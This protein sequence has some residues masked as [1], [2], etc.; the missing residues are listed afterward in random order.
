MTDFHHISVADTAAMLAQ[1][2]VVIA[3]IRDEQ[4]FA[5][6]HIAGAIHLSNGSLSQFIQQVEFEKPI[7]VVCYHGNSS[8]GAAQYLAQQGFAQVYSMDGGFSEWQKM[9]PF[10][11]SSDA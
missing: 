10:E 5:S 2:Q 4:S 3:D 6:G 1:Q 8:Q 11:Q 9:Q 7:I